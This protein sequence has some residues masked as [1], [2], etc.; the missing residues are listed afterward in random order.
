MRKSGTD[1]RNKVRFGDTLH[2]VTGV[3]TKAGEQWIVV[4]GVDAGILVSA[5]HP[6]SI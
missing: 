6:T 2:P 5:I 3:F 1:I 4:Y